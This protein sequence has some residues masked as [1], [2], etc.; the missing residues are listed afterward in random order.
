MNELVKEIE[1]IK[2]ICKILME[3]QHYGKLGPAGIFAIIQKCKAVGVDPMEGLNGG[4][5]YVS[6]KVEMSSVMMS[7]K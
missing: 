2:E 6:G 1:S 7:S 5:Y 4:M 3:T